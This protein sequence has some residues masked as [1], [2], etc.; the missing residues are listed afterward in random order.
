MR[1]A[2][3]W[4]G[5]AIGATIGVFAG[6]PVGALIGAFVGHWFDQ[7][8]DR[9]DA[10]AAKVSPEQI[11]DIFFRTAFQMMGHVAK[12]DGR[13]SEDHIRAARA[14]M[15]E[16]RLNEEQVQ[17]AIDCFTAGKTPDFPLRDALERLNAVCK[18]RPDLK[19]MFVQMQVQTAL[20]AGALHRPARKI[21]GKICAA[22][23]V[24]TFELVQLEAL[25]RMQQQGAHM[26]R[27]D[28]LADAYAVLGVTANVSDVEVTKAYRRLMNQNHP[29]KLVAKGL[30]ESMMNMAAEKTRQIRAAYERIC[31]ARG[32]R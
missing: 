13:V 7:E 27:A 4:Q 23:E 30:P 15:A 8:S 19:R 12:A 28:A 26:Q 24:S 5:K 22:L 11:Q 2:K 14:M 31:E 3:A 29:D 20:R 18:G 10:T 32:I 21:I 6:G 17:L 25:L 9:D 16:L 1:L